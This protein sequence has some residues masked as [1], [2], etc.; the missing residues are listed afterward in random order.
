MAELIAPSGPVDIAVVGFPETTPDERVTA[1]VHDAVASG[2][3]RVLD[4]LVVSKADDGALTIVDVDDADEALDLLGFPADLPGFLAEGDA[5]D[6]GAEL[7][8]GTSAVIIAWEN[9]WAARLRLALSEADG[10][11]A[12]H[13]RI[14][15]DA[16]AVA[17]QAIVVTED[18]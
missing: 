2:A 3:V 10:V 15:P 1:A 13:E 4:A 16:V 12:L 8:P 6:V 11:I 5:L 18:A 17:V 9:V 7:P 14:E